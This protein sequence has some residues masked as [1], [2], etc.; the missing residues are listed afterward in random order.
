MGPPILTEQVFGAFDDVSRLYDVAHCHFKNKIF[1]FK[2]I[3]S[4]SANEMLTGKN[5]LSM[6]SFTNDINQNNDNLD[7]TL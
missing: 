2:R 1:Y 3:F 4:E 5:D 7:S 6:N